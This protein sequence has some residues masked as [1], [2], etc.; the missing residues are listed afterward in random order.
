MNIEHVIILLQLTD[1]SH[2][3]M[4]NPPLWSKLD[5]LNSSDAFPLLMQ[6]TEKRGGRDV[7]SASS[8][9]TTTTTTTTAVAMML[10][11]HSAVTEAA[12]VV[13]QLP[14]LFSLDQWPRCNCCWWW[15]QYS[16]RRS[17]FSIHALSYSLELT[18]WWSAWSNC[19]LCTISAEPEDVPVRLAFEALAH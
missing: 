5:W 19:E 4:T 16:E 1:I 3:V 12:A 2:D 18:A 7:N 14:N 10:L 8:T 15:W 11:H 6:R 17:I 9:T 13:V